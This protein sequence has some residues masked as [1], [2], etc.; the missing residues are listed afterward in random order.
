MRL[1]TVLALALF[2]ACEVE[3]PLDSG[4]E[5]DTE[6]LDETDVSDVE[7]TDTQEE[8][9]HWGYDDEATDALGPASWGEH[10][11]ECD[12]EAQSP[13]DLIL[14]NIEG[15]AE[16][17]FSFEYGASPLSAI[18]NGHTLQYNASITKNAAGFPESSQ[19]GKLIIGADTYHLVQF[20][21]HTRSEHWIEGV[22]ADLE[23]HLVHQRDDGAYAVVGVMAR[24]AEDVGR[25]N[26]FVSAADAQGE[27]DGALRFHEALA[28][29]PNH[30]G[31]ATP[32]VDSFDFNLWFGYL[33]N[34]MMLGYSGSL[35]TPG[36]AEGVSWFVSRTEMNLRLEDVTAFRDV[37][38]MN[39]RPI[40]REV[41]PVLYYGLG[42]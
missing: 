42:G 25:P 41:E 37:F 12:G 21:F 34:T 15:A 36:C 11:E 31:V 27:G 32:M 6:E 30:E 17:T 14:A 16:P 4:L 40:Q 10:W 3:D 33:P 5:T 9:P 13:V 29:E 20:H 35:T 2:T 7:E 19:G 39:N 28:L 18:N 23:M 8:A 26:L 1:V 38:P 24:G 22:D